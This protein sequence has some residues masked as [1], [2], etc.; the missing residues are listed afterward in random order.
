MRGPTWVRA[1]F[2]AVN[3]ASVGLLAQGAPA[4]QAAQQPAEFR[5]VHMG[6]EVRLVVAGPGASDRARTERAARAAFDRVAELEAVLSDW[7]PTSELRRLSRQP[8]GAWV[9]VSPALCAVLALALDVA[10]A[11]DGQFDPT[12]GPLTVL[13]REVQR[14][15][16][17]APDSVWAAAR[18]RVG[19]RFVEL[20]TMTHRVRLLRDSMRLDLGAIAKGWILDAALAD[21]RR[22]GVS[23]AL[24]EAG[25]D[26]A[27]FGA[28]M[29]ASAGPRGWRIAV[30]G[31]GPDSVLVLTAGAVS[32]SGPAEQSIP[33]RDGARESHVINPRTGHGAVDGRSI[34][35]VGPSAAITDAL[36]TA[37]TLVPAPSMAAL[38][39]RFGVRIV[40]GAEPTLR[41]ASSPTSRDRK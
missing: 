38:A 33:H 4:R 11:T 6:M 22:V 20:D 41:P 2:V 19:Y 36:A 23:A 24:I 3:L 31:A 39:T 21:V 7:R 10:R 8:A 1:T 12:I 9:S 40:S 25:G 13:W 35:V 5:E 32:T 17:P 14:T 15:G 16:K 18:A 26:I 29:G 37:L 28:P 34:T 30:P 27:L